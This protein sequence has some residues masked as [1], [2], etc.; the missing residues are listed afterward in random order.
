MAVCYKGQ[1]PVII[2]NSFFA[3]TCRV[4]LPTCP[5]PDGTSS[6]ALLRQ[7]CGS[8]QLHKSRRKAAHRAAFTHATNQ[9]FGRRAR[10]PASEPDEATGKPDRRGA[11]ISHRCQTPSCS[12]SRNCP[13]GPAITQRRG[14]RAQCWLRQQSLLRS[15][16]ENSRFLP[17]VVSHRF[18]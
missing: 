14:S 9:R 10:C 16:A 13:V 17:S 11:L 7:R 1:R 12:R 8:A 3:L 2:R 6:S 18:G 4:G 15:S 5:S